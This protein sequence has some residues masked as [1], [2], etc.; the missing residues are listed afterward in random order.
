MNLRP[1]V[2]AV[3]S[4]L[5]ATGS[6][7]AD[8]YPRQPHVD[9]IHY[10]FAIEITEGTAHIEAETL[11]TF[12]LLAPVPFIEVD[13]RSAS[14]AGGMTVRRVTRGTE[15][16]E[17]SHA[18]DR[19]RLPVP[20]A[21]R[22]GEELTYAITY[23]GD[24]GAGVPLATN[25]HGEAVRFSESWPNQ[26]RQW[27]P[28]IDHPYDK[29]TGEFVITAPAYWQVVANG[30]LVAE[31]DLP[32]NRRRTHWRQT[33]PIATWLFAFGA[34]RFHAQHHGTAVGVP[35][36][37]WAFPQDAAAAHALF[38]EPSKRA[39]EFFAARIGPYPYEKLANVQ[40]TGW[41]GA[42]EN[43]TVIFYGEKA[44]AAGRGPVA[45]E[46]AH[47]WFG[48]SVTQRDWDDIWLSEGFATYFALLYREHAEG[49]DAFVAGLQRDRAAVVAAAAKMPDTPVVH[50]NLSDMEGVLNRFV[51]EK[52]AWVLHML[53]RHVGEEAFWEGIQQYYRRYRDR[54]AAT[55]D[56]R[57]VMEGASGKDLRQFF[58]QWLT[59]GGNPALAASWQYHPS[60]RVVQLTIRQTHTGEPYAL[61]VD[62]GLV[63]ASGTRIETVHL[64]DR[65][66]TVTWESASAPRELV[67]DPNT[68]L[69][70][71][72]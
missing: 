18:A 12:R 51:Y 29:A 45:H 33:A 3:I 66:T 57:R 72:F 11:A 32:A 23:A 64:V 65:E 15:D 53:R 30:A 21:A 49:R 27:L 41:T 46:I 16:V 35:L 43:A 67:I 20:S 38:A 2:R 47:Q 24:P 8:T 4:L 19:L 63:M 61:A 52:G 44:V 9:A 59:R 31:V 34:A 58:S 69:L 10:R 70:A 54:N 62:V 28:V 55:D 40:A 26:A 13:L 36:Q 42:L 14:A 68:W 1:H 37:S 71:Q 7:G 17:F 6:A 39:L 48:N 25:M 5:L 60:R 22:A 56:F 50:R